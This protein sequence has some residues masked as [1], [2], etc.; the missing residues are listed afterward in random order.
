MC[1]KSYWEPFTII[2]DSEAGNISSLP[3][4]WTYIA[5]KDSSVKQ[6]PYREDEKQT[7]PR[8]GEIMVL[9][10]LSEYVRM[11]LFISSIVCLS[12]KY[13]SPGGS[14]SSRISRSICENSSYYLLNMKKVNLLPC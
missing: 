2:S 3:N 8:S 1:S 12:L 13:A 6:N 4:A 7:F 5:A 9:S 14:L 10:S 11:M